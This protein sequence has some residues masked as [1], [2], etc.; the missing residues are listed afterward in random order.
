MNLH[1]DDVIVRDNIVSAGEVIN[2]FDQVSLDR[3]SDPPTTLTL[4]GII[5]PLER[6]LLASIETV[7]IPEGHVGL[8]QLRSTAARAGLI[9]PATYADAGFRGTL[10]LEVFNSNKW[11][12]HL[13][14][15]THLWNLVIVAA[16]LEP[17]YNGRYQDQGKGVYQ[18]KA[19]SYDKDIYVENNF[20]DPSI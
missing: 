5:N 19:L 18:S 16:P 1:V 14:A 6:V 20:G 17:M 11:G 15:G 7:E 3:S 9:A 2:L 8:V 10:T 13:I 4:D 12:I